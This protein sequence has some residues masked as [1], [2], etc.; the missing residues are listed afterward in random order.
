MANT[1]DDI[2]PKILAQGLMALRNATVMPALV[3]TDYSQD[4]AQEGDTVNVP[5]P[6]NIAVRDVTPG[7]TP[8]QAPDI[9]PTT[10]PIALDKWKEAPFYLTDKDMQ[11]AM[12]GVVPMQVSEAVGSLA[13]QVNSDIFALYKG[14]YGSAGTA[15]TTP[16]A[17]DLSEATAAR[18]VLNNQKA[19]TARR[20][21]VIDPDAEANALG[22]RAIQDAG[23][24]SDTENTLRTG[25][26][27]SVLGFDWFMDQQVP[28]HTAGSL[29]N[30]TVNGAHSA[31]V[32]TVSV[33]NGDASAEDLNEGDLITFAGDSQTYAVTGDVSFTSSGNA[34]VGI[35]PALQ[36]A[37]SGGE[38]LSFEGDHT[39]NLA[40]QRGALAMAVRPLAA[41]GGFSGGS[42][43]QS[44]TDPVSRLTLRLEVSRQAKQTNWSFDILYGVGVVRPELAARLYG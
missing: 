23:F 37:L 30:A 20:R 10:K 40:F 32:E 17:S 6:G 43:I 8:V 28:T 29:S 42:I 14:I 26:I 19:P 2:I 3:N 39:V 27:G 34:N 12:S 33:T 4:A 24:R 15:G 13:E 11:E 38:A 5:I 21:L 16:F 44:A 35:S 31:G 25:Q 22:I 7:V 41:P 18:K 36:V 1:L 9:G